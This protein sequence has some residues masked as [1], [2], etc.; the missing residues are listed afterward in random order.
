M[1]TKIWLGRAASKPEIYT[2]VVAG[3]WGSA[4][5][6][7][8]TIGGASIILTAGTAVA[9]TDIAAAIN[10]MINGSSVVGTESRSEV[11]TSIG[12]FDGIT[13]TVTS[14]T[15][16]ITGTSGIPFTMTVSETST[17]GTLTLTNVQDATG[18]NDVANVDNWGGALPGASDDV[19][20]P[21]GSA[22]LLYGLTALNGVTLANFFVERGFSNSIGLP[23]L[24]SNGYIEYLD[25]YLTCKSTV[26]K[27]GIG[28]SGV[29]STRIKLDAS[30]VQT[31][32]TVEYSEQGESQDTGAVIFK[33]THASNVVIVNGGSLS[34]ARYAGDTTVI[35]TLRVHNG[36]SAWIGD[37]TTLTT[38]YVQ[39]ASIQVVD[40]A[41]TT[42]E[43]ESGTAVIN[44]DGAIGTLTC[45]SGFVSYR[46]AGNITTMNLGGKGSATFSTDG[47][48][49]TRTVST[50]NLKRGGQVI[51][52]NNTTFSAIS[53]QSDVSSFSA[54]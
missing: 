37:A 6:V 49:L 3:T 41:I 43:M 34:T 22:S 15:V 25:T 36:A 2:I 23:Y 21:A 50:L 52:G 18:P 24:N 5:T 44:G 39:S 1:A 30:S 10:A 19:F 48:T 32:L 29:G 53:I 31:A 47:T 35:A 45:E 17:S 4:E 38:V 8:L 14:S 16:I 46:G 20:I 27:V 11:G 42:L 9:T 51:D 7:T 12:Q 28:G 40:A 13:S 26:I 54:A 33:G